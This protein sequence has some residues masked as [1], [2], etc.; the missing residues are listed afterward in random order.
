MEQNTT[1]HRLHQTA[2]HEAGHAVISW[3]WRRSF[4]KLTIIPDGE[5]LGLV[6]GSIWSS[7]LPQCST[8]DLEINIDIL[9]A[10]EAA[11]EKHCGANRPGMGWIEDYKKAAEIAKKWAMQTN[12][13]REYMED[14]ELFISDSNA[15]LCMYS[16]DFYFE[17]GRNVERLMDRPH[18]WSS[19][20]ALAEK[21]IKYRELSGDKAHTIIYEQWN[22]VRGDREEKKHEKEDLKIGWGY[23]KKGK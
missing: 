21:I 8:H 1:N 13:P 16:C 2:Y 23:Y 9:L 11:E 18:I 3:Y 10:G 12:Q 19:I 4:E 20:E 22:K 7:D 17:F 6:K 14:I 15:E 5:I